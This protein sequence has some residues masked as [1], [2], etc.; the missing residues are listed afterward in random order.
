MNRR[1]RGPSSQGDFP[2]VMYAVAGL[3]NLVIRDDPLRRQLG[4]ADR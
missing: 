4:L 3:T 2:G 1:L